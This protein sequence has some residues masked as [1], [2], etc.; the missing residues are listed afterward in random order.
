MAGNP[1]DYNTPLH[2]GFAALIVSMLLLQLVNIVYLQQ[3]NPFLYTDAFSQTAANAYSTAIQL[4]LFVTSWMIAG[5]VFVIT[6]LR[7]NTITI[8]AK[9]PT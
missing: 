8:S 2:N 7:K 3:F 9:T 6:L 5:L 1:P 4:I